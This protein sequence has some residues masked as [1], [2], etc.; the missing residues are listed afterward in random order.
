MPYFTYKE[1]ISP[2]FLRNCSAN[3]NI[4][5]TIFSEYYFIRLVL[6]TA[7]VEKD[8][9]VIEN[10]NNFCK[11]PFQENHRLSTKIIKDAISP[12]NLVDLE[13][14]LLKSN[15][16]NRVLFNEILSEYSY[17]FFC[18]KQERYT[19]SF[20]H[21]YR[22]LEFIAYSF[23]LVHASSS[24]NFKGTYSDLKNFFNKDGNELSFLKSFVNNLLSGD[25]VL[26]ASINIVIEHTDPTIQNKIYFAFKR[27]CSGQT[28][29]AFDDA[30]F[31]ISYEFKSTIDFFYFIRNR[32]FHFAV[33]GHQT[34]FSTHSIVDPDI[35]FK[36]IVDGFNNYIVYV[37]IEILKTMIDRWK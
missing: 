14:Y 2:Y 5:S 17:H 31:K 1:A 6:G 24:R 7:T 20:L 8:G 33:G 36:C 30:S 34:N 9:H 23:P 15:S 29:L 37:Y 27:I 19:Q 26:S 16:N 22:A 28:Y 35:L 11:I 3:L 10:R 32:Y 21:L 4:D 13:S 18:I 25:P 12:L